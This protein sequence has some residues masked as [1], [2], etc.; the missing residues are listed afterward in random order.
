MD[1]EITKRIPI[2]NTVKNIKHYLVDL[3]QEEEPSFPV[4]AVFGLVND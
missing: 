3:A 2:L 1:S 4:R